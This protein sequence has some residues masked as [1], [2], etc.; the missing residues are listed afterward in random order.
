LLV[1]RIQEKLDQ[2][3]APYSIVHSVDPFTGDGLVDLLPA[4]VSKAHALAWWVEQQGFDSSVIVYAGDS[5]NDLAALTAGYR[6]IVVGNAAR[7]LARQVQ[8]VHR[9][10]GWSK[11]LYLARKNATSGVLEGC[12]WFGL[13]ERPTDSGSCSPPGFGKEEDNDS[14]S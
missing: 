12:L 8:A 14:R 9:E 10:R 4:G 6:A 11:R 1:E 7:S 5:G 13:I 2:A 3:G